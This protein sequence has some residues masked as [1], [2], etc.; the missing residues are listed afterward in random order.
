M[1]KLDERISSLETKLKQLKVRQQR[2]RRRTNLPPIEELPMRN[3]KLFDSNTEIFA[4]QVDVPAFVRALIPQLSNDLYIVKYIRLD[5]SCSACVFH[6]A[7]LV[8][9]LSN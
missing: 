8:V 7:K 5:P 9:E 2:C 1:P 3:L 6:V 4:V